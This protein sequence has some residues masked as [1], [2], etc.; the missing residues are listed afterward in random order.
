MHLILYQINQ[1]INVFLLDDVSV[2]IEGTLSESRFAMSPPLR[3]YQVQDF[4]TI[5]PTVM[6]MI[7]RPKMHVAPQGKASDILHELKQVGFDFGKQIS[8]ILGEKEDTVKDYRP[9]S[10]VL[11][12]FHPLMQTTEIEGI[13]WQGIRSRKVT[14]IYLAPEIILATKRRFRPFEKTQDFIAVAPTALVNVDRPNK[15]GTTFGIAPL[16]IEAATVVNAN[17]DGHLEIS[18]NE[19]VVGSGQLAETVAKDKKLGK[20]LKKAR[21]DVKNHYFPKEKYTTFEWEVPFKCHVIPI[22]G[23]TLICVQSAPEY[24]L[25]LRD[26][27]SSVR[28]WDYRMQKPVSHILER[29]SYLIQQTAFDDS[30]VTSSPDETMLIEYYLRENGYG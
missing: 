19:G 2:H 13:W 12:V 25:L 9:V 1:N 23:R 17:I 6:T 3:R 22:Q 26:V 20:I 21:N 4:A 14:R 7:E 24:N 15:R 29:I 30:I 27:Q 11:P 5:T 8:T 10:E 16:S 18:K 28:I